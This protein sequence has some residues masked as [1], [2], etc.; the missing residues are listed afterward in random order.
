MLRN[1]ILMA[2]QNAGVTMES[3]NTAQAYKD[4]LAE[5]K[6]NLVHAIN[7][8]YVTAGGA[9]TVM[10]AAEFKTKAEAEGCITYTSLADIKLTS[11]LYSTNPNFLP[12]AGSPALSGA[13]FTGLPSFFTTVAYRGAFGADNWTAGW[14]NWDPQNTVY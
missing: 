2:T 14:T 10:T 9:E 5:F 3:A 1:S 8:P 13:D 11:P 4:G 12:A 7:N 6:N